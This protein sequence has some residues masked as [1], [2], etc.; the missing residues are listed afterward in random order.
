MLRNVFLKNQNDFIQRQQRTILVY[1]TK[2]FNFFNFH[3]HKNLGE[4]IASID[5]KRKPIF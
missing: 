3:L 4:I 1:M 5:E 2:T